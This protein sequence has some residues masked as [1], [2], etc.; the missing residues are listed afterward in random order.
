MRAIARA[1]A[2]AGRRPLINTQSKRCSE[3]T[4]IVSSNISAVRPT[5][6]YLA[7]VRPKA[8]PAP[9]ATGGAASA[10]RIPV[11]RPPNARSPRVSGPPGPLWE[12]PRALHACTLHVFSL[13]ATPA[14]LCASILNLPRPTHPPPTEAPAA[15]TETIPTTPIFTWPATTTLH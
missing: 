4:P 14:A 2:K 3:R 8:K 7:V 13:G 15:T 11:G 5:K 12:E 10:P 6:R 1:G 9:R